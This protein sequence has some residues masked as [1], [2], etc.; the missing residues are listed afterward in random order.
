MTPGPGTPT[1]TGNNTGTGM[2]GTG[3]VPNPPPPTGMPSTPIMGDQVDS[4]CKVDTA[5]PRRVLRLSNDELLATLQSYGALDATAIPAAFA[6]SLVGGTPNEGLTISRDY[7]ENVDQMATNL[8]AKISGSPAMNQL[9]ALSCPVTDFG[10]VDACTN[11][12]LTRAT[13]KLFRGMGTTQD[14]TNLMTLVKG[15]ASRSD[16]KTAL[17]Y[18]VRAM[19]LNPKSLYLLE[20][21]D[22]PANANP[23]TPTHLSAGELASFLSYRILGRPPAETLITAVKPI[24]AA[25]T[26]QSLQQVLSS[27]FKPED[28]QRGATTFFSAWMKLA[29]IPTLDATGF[30]KKH[31][32]VNQAFLTKIQTEAYEGIASMLKMPDVDFTKVLTTDLRSA[33]AGDST[34]TAIGTIGGRPGLFTLPGVLMVNSNVDHTNIPRRG[35]FILKELFCELVPPPPAE[36]VTKLPPLTGTPTER[37]RFEHIEKEDLCGGCHQRVN[38]PAFTLEVYNEIGVARTQDEHNNPLDTATMH[39]VG[40]EIL[41]F[42]DAK[43]MFTQ[44]ASKAAAQNCL[45]IQTFR[46]VARRF[47]RGADG[48]EDACLIRDIAAAGRMTNFKILDIFKDALVRTAL[49]KRGS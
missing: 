9:A 31:P 48:V 47:E 35:R 17:E 38:H 12:F 7:H 22:L 29:D 6:P 20:G 33:S 18:A 4:L 24:A 45:A 36:L 42:K 10:R 49:A 28:L 16:G 13:T 14:V 30:A 5:H 11:T 46:H 2:T 8:A 37:A 40:K 23:A 21:M 44:A 32:Q 34:S 15:V 27:Q 1:G 3:T 19:V 41:T 25:P 43:D 26:A 39:Q